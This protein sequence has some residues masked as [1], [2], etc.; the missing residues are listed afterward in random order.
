MQNIEFELSEWFIPLCLIAAAGVAFLLYTRSAP[1]SK[2]TNKTLAGFRFVLI[3]LLTILLLNPLINRFISFIEDPVVVIAVDNSSS[4]LNYLDDTELADIRSFLKAL[5]S[6][7][8]SKNNDVEIHSL[9]GKFENL[10]SL[11][12]SENFTDLN[13]F[14][15][16]IQ[17]DFDNRNLTGIYLLSD[18]NYNQGNSPAY[19]PFKIPIHSLAVGDTT[20]KSDIL[21]KNILFNKI[22]YQGNKFPV[23]VEVVN[24]GFKNGSTNVKIY[25]K[26]KSVGSKEINFNSEQGLT[27]IELE[28][29]AEEKGL[30]SLRV[31]LE[32][33]KDELISAN[34]SRNIF[35]DVVEGKQNILMLAYAP[36]PDIKALSGVIDNNQNYELDIF[37][38]GIGELDEGKKYDLIIAHNSF[39]RFNR[40]SKYLTEF[41]K[42]GIPIFNILGS[43]TNVPRMQQ[44]NPDFG[45][46]QTG[47]QRDNVLTTINTNFRLFTIP[48]SSYEA[49]RAFPPIA[50][51]FGDFRM[52]PLADV[53]LFQK[54]GSIT[55]T[56]PLLYVSREDDSKVAYLM[57]E[58][59]WRW[60]LQEFAVNESTEAFDQLFLKLIQY[61]S[62]QDDKRKFKFFPNKNEYYENESISF[63][64]EVYNDIYERVFGNEIEVRVTDSQGNSSNYSFS[65]VSSYSKLEI[66]DFSP[67]I[68]SF[69]ASLSIDGKKE[70]A[71]G[72]FSVKEL[73]LEGLDQVAQHE[74][75]RQISSN[76][77]GKFYHL[78]DREHLINDA[79][80]T[81][82]KGIIHTS[83]DTVSMI[84]IRW[85]V[86]ILLLLASLEWFTRKYSGG[87]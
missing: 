11:E 20:Q 16:D 43:R 9:A 71:Y 28:V 39:D 86:V 74:I 23:L 26:G 79:K 24:Y 81:T 70:M 45:F 34:N 30:Q 63:Q 82:S 65:P 52:N 58:G 50:V 5:Q 35:V 48:E 78:I 17:S 69:Q 41:K 14:L 67:G 80:E 55:T 56:K 54:V 62:T 25:Q 3:S 85:I 8:E 38:P 47:A 15:R 66:S 4:L 13:G 1:W 31:V 64:A 19:F 75:L 42:Q 2:T 76:S 27:R 59:I 68:Y 87:Y 46:A 7:L 37:I 61:L 60:R 53:I 29:E 83:E 57:G 77:G 32:P 33:M 49:F 73:Q 6:T 36:H 40:M 18:G 84:N 10:D 51:P 44:S 22:A 21:I 72:K 12:F